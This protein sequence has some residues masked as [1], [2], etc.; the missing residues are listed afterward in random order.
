MYRR[1]RKHQS[2]VVK[3]V[4]QSQ[5]PPDSNIRTRAFET[6]AGKVKGSSGV[7]NMDPQMTLP[8]SGPSVLVDMEMPDVQDTSIQ[9]HGNAFASEFPFDP[10]F[11][12]EI[13]AL[14]PNPERREKYAS[15]RASLSPSG[16]V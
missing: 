14:E 7:L 8:V 3:H 10:G 4:L 1:K 16:V 15:V 6:N 5:V 13:A 9:P 11:I 12:D 2:E